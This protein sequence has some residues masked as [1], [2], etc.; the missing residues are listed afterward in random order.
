M[1]NEKQKEQLKKIG[2][3]DF[4]NI[5]KQDVI[6]AAIAY[7]TKK[8][9]KETFYYCSSNMNISVLLDAIKTLSQNSAEIDKKILDIISEVVKTL[10]ANL[11]KANTQEERE[12]VREDLMECLRVAREMSNK[13]FNKYMNT[14]VL[15][16]GC[17]VLG[18]IALFALASRNADG[19][20]DDDFDPYDFC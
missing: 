14:L 15:I 18:V 10:N 5:T 16:T 4:N 2:V 8:I 11:S 7:I 3:N 17:F 9:D 19:D 12:K 20:N 6:K 1:L 13:E